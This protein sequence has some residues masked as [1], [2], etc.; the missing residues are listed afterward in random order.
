[1]ISVIN[2]LLAYQF[3]TLYPRGW[4][5]DGKCANIG[6]ADRDHMHIA[7]RLRYRFSS[8]ELLKTVNQVD[9]LIE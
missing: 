6:F 4:T 3:F 1:M 9:H 2:Q 8:E 5:T 7:Q